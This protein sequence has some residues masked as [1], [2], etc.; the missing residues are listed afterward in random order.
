MA[1][2]VGSRGQKRFWPL[3]VA[4]GLLPR[5]KTFRAHDIEFVPSRNRSS[6]PHVFPSK[7]ST[8]GTRGALCIA[9]FDS[10]GIAANNQ[11]MP[12]QHVE[13]LTAKTHWCKRWG[14]YDKAL[15]KRGKL[16]I[17]LGQNATWPLGKPWAWSKR[18]TTFSNPVNPIQT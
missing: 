1:F 3:Q 8:K 10:R 14:P 15:A 6:N 17:C 4:N 5:V 9:I 12:A 11:S 16:D 7:P 13:W 2:M 18:V